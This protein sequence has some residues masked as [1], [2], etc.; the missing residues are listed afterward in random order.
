[1]LFPPKHIRKQKLTEVN[2]LAQGPI[3]ENGGKLKPSSLELQSS[4]S[5]KTTTDAGVIYVRI[6]QF[7][8]LES[9]KDLQISASLN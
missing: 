6:R 1:M 3:A 4:T 5:P 8:R 9:M 2:Q 7:N